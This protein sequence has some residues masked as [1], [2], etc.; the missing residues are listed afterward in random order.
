MA[1]IKHTWKL[2]TC[3]LKQH[4]GTAHRYLTACV[5]ERL[6]SYMCRYTFPVWL[7]WAHHSQIPCGSTPNCLIAASW[8]FFGHFNSLQLGHSIV[9]SVVLS[10]NYAS[11]PDEE[12]KRFHRQQTRRLRQQV[13]NTYTSSSATWIMHN[14]TCLQA[15]ATQRLI[16]TW[17]LL[18]V[19]VCLRPSFSRSWHSLVGI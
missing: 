10:W 13:H 15:S 2:F 3:N 14:A 11:T 9:C 17:H 8:T 12:A 16:K 5:A 6:E 4:M 18:Y 19:L 7:C 1:K